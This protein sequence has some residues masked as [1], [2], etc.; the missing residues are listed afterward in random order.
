[1]DIGAVL[2]NR[3]TLR[4]RIGKG[5]MGIVYR[6]RQVSLNRLVALKMIL[7][8]QLASE[9]DLRRFHTEAAAAANLDHPGV[10]PIYEVGEHQGQ[11]F[12]SMGF[13]EGESLAA[14]IARGP[15][16]PRDSAEIVRA[17]SEAVQY[18]HEKGVIHRDL[19]PANILLDSAGHPRITDFGLA[20]RVT[21]DSNLTASGQVVGTPSYMPPEQ[22][23]GV[24]VSCNRSPSAADP[25]GAPEWKQKSK[26]GYTVR[27]FPVKPERA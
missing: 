23:G 8:G 3:Y 21:R 10:V 26:L 5:A 24:N 20:R 9:Q 11:H 17:V 12:F 4:A 1:M 6:A 19:K 2:N 7:A 13:V 14:R 16:A 18:A 25:P 27:P 15:L 22:C